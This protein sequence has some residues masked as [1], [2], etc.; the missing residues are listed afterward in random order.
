MPVTKKQLKQ[1]LQNPCSWAF[2]NS[3]LL[4][5]FF[6]FFFW[7]LV[8]FWGGG[9]LVPNYSDGSSSAWVT[10]MQPQDAGFHAMIGLKAAF[11]FWRQ[12]FKSWF[13][14]HKCGVYYLCLG[15]DD[16]LIINFGSLLLNKKWYKSKL[17]TFHALLS[18][19][20]H[21]EMY[22]S[23]WH[24]VFCLLIGLSKF[25]LHFSFWSK[26]KWKVEYFV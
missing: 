15:G 18:L 6:L 22:C 8:F 2:K 21:S 1:E 16:G 13:W 5:K 23:I 3:F 11:G 10:S 4:G 17:K 9:C 12:G 14:E 20:S 7:D 19:L 24:E 25:F 26:N